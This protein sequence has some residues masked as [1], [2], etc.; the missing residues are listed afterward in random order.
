MWKAPVNLSDIFND[1]E[2]ND[3]RQNVLGNYSDIKASWYD[4]GN[5]INYLIDSKY[6]YTLTS[7]NLSTPTPTFNWDPKIRVEDLYSNE[8]IYVCNTPSGDPAEYMCDPDVDEPCVDGAPGRTL[9][10]GL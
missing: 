8:E 4:E 10:S 5:D 3:P 2:N 1:T 9:I 7:M 6:V